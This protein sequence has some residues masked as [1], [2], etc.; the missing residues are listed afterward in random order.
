MSYNVDEFL[1]AMKNKTNSELMEI[2]KTADPNISAIKEKIKG[3][4]AHLESEDDSSGLSQEVIS[5]FQRRISDKQIEWLKRNNSEKGRLMNQLM[6]KLENQIKSLVSG[7]EFYDLLSKLFLEVKQDVGSSFEVHIPKNSDP[8][9]FKSASGINQNI[10]ADL[11]NVGVLVKRLDYPISVEN[12]LE[13]RLAKSKA[14]LIIEA[15]RGLWDDLED[16]PWQFQQ[17]LKNLNSE[18]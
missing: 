16:S 9:K 15:S 17:I 10:V 18:K 6:A 7:P 3:K 2:Q 14:D 11:D 4:I 13:S 5:D 12:T 1:E 8:G